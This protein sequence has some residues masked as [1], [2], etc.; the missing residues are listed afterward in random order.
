M[1]MPMNMTMPMEMT[2]PQMN[3]WQPSQLALIFV[4]WAVMMFGMMLPS[5]SPMILL[6]AA[7]NRKR[8]K[9]QQPFVSTGVFVLG[10]LIVWT[11]F[12]AVAT[13]A[14]AKLHSAALASPM[15]VSTSKVLGGVLLI[16]AGIFQLTPIKNAC[17]SHCRSPLDFITTGWRDGASGAFTM[18]VRHGAY[19]VGC[20][21]VLMLLLFVTGVMNIL[22]IAII[23]GF[24]LLEKAVP[25]KASSWLSR[26][27][28]LLLLGW[29]VWLLAR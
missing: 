6:F 19:C 11:I 21:W 15:M 12:A 4:M 29:G 3:P 14:Q 24:V 17:L 26:F 20:C 5:A 22:W 10:Y 18:G 27:A 28:G 25:A 9:Q 7:V 2:M 8:R 16:A 23:A 13:L 1:D